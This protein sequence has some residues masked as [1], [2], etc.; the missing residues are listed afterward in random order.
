[1]NSIIDIYKKIYKEVEDINAQIDIK[2]AEFKKK[3]EDSN[4]YFT[5]RIENLETTLKKVDDYLLR[6]KGFQELAKKSLESANVLTIEAPP[7]YRVNLNRLRNWAMLIDPSSSN[8]PYAQRVY[9]VAKCDECFLEKKKKEFT[10]KIESLKN[11]DAK[12]VTAE[13]GQIEKDIANLESQLKGYSSSDDVAVFASI[14]IKENEKHWLTEAPESFIAD[15]NSENIAPGAIMLPFKLH[16]D[17]TNKIKTQFG[18]FYDENHQRVLIP[19]EFDNSKDFILSVFCSPSRSKELDKGI[20]NLLLELVNSHDLGNQNIYVI[21]AARYNSS[22][23]GPLRAIEGTVAINQIPRNPEQLTNTL[24]NIIVSHSDYD[25][26]IELHDSVREYNDSLTDKSHTLPTSLLVLYGWPNSYSKTDRELV[27][28]IVMNYERYG[29]SV[30]TVSLT[31]ND[32][33]TD[34]TKNYLPEYAANNAIRIVMKSKETTIAEPEKQIRNF[35]WYTY[36]SELHSKYVEDIRNY[37]VKS[38]KRGNEYTTWFSLNSEDLPSYTREYKPIS[39]PFGMDGK[40]NIH[41]ISFENENFAAYLVGASRS[42]KSTL[43][44]TLIAG[45]IR[46]YHPDNVELWLADFKQ[47]EFKR[48]M[49]HLPPHVKYVLLDESEELVFD[50]IDRLTNEMFERQKLFSRMGKQRIDQV[51]TTKLE[52]PLPVIF[53]ILDEFSIMSQAIA[54]SPSYKLKLQNLLAKGAALGIKFLF[55]SQTF[56]TG[57]GGLTS[58][59]RAQIQQRI[60]MKG[61][62]E[63]ISETLELS[64]NLRTDQVKNWMD[65]L[66]P[67]YA[68]V[69]YRTGPDTPPQVKRFLVLYF[70]D[71]SVRD[72]M[73]DTIN[74]NLIKNEEYK[75]NEI[76]SYVDKKPVLV[77]GNTFDAFNWDEL[78]K[79]ADSDIKTNGADTLV[80]F[81]TPRL[82]SRVKFTE[83][84]NETRENILLVARLQEQQCAMSIILSSIKSYLNQKGNVEIWTYSKNAMYMEYKSVLQ[85]TGATIVEDIDAVC[86]SIRDLKSKIKEKQISNTLV[87]LLGM[88]RICMDFDFID[89]ETESTYNNSPVAQQ[90]GKLIESAAAVKTTSEENLHNYAMAWLKEREILKLQLQKEGK[91]PEEIKSILKEKQIDFKKQYEKSF[92]GTLELSQSQSQT[93]SNKDS[94]VI[95]ETNKSNERKDR[96]GAYNAQNDF[97]YVVKQGSRMGYHFMLCVNNYSDIKQCG[98]K[99]RDLFRYRLAFQLSVQDSRDLFDNKSASILPEHICKYDSGL[100]QYSFRPYLHKGIGWDGWYINED[101]SVFNP[102]SAIDN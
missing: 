13:L 23:L 59:A 91:N 68:L 49:N 45:I 25:E 92:D 12:D 77:D 102:Y 4:L 62:R 32:S 18:K 78:S 3:S 58:T 63:E 44:H 88:D 74:R 21:D 41:D 61:A 60:S 99:N 65:A 42:G 80:S 64:S 53:V 75:P 79:W 2:R 69:K 20:Q 98:F 83:I 72:T 71:Y 50:L 90:R 84:S 94:V 5:D 27:Q 82:M 54:E 87:V 38:N 52:K 66:P 70:K 14:V 19:Y 16:K 39:L 7:G 24:E 8:D 51:D 56:T 33:D 67:H 48:Y 6:V 37:V 47:L 11:A 36:N 28:R 93:H 57:V 81:G 10:T 22:A 15:K 73:I 31:M 35:A 101:G 34:K 46:N 97:D 96:N 95:E 43:L 1:M 55:S 86:N 76:N 29:L 89:S 17:E 40:E 9:V 26:I 30:I 100:E 85:D